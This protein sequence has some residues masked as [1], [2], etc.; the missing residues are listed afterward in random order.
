MS[1]QQQPQDEPNHDEL[2]LLLLTLGRTRAQL[3]RDGVLFVWDENRLRYWSL[4]S[5][6]IVSPAQL[7]TYVDIAIDRTE[8]RIDWITRRLINGRIDYPGWATLVQQELKAENVGL[9]QLA[10]GGGD[11]WDATTA[12]RL[13]QR[14]RLLYQKLTDLGLEWERGE[15]SPRQMLNRIGMA[16]HAARGTYEGMIRGVMLDAG[17]DMERNVLA[18]GAHHCGECPALTEQ[19]WVELGTLPMIGDRECMTRD[20]CSMEYDRSTDTQD[21]N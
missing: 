13:G 6:S 1:A 5:E 18:D 14:M 4:T 2:A 19:G 7:R 12:G 17:Y 3:I 10:I 11:M 20:M 8:N 9:A 16:V 15:V 21:L